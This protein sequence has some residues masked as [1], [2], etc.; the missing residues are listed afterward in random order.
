MYALL[1][2]AASAKKRFSTYLAKVTSS[3]DQKA[4]SQSDVLIKDVEICFSNT[5]MCQMFLFLRH[6]C[7]V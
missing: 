1:F 7:T 4:K 6:F 3:C 2:F 5:F